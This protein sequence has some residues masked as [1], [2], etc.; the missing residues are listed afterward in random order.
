[1]FYYWFGKMF[2]VRNF[3]CIKIKRPANL[4][5]A[6]RLCGDW[7]CKSTTKYLIRKIET[8]K[9]FPN[10]QKFSNG[11]ISRYFLVFSWNFILNSKIAIWRKYRDYS[12]VDNRAR[13]QH[14]ACH[15]YATCDFAIRLHSYGMLALFGDTIFYRATFPTGIK[16]KNL[17]CWCSNTYMA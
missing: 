2:C 10:A 8:Q 4:S 17:F 13:L 11:K 6:K 5:I 14:P 1:M 9:I 3:H 7:R 12:S 16:Q 15:R